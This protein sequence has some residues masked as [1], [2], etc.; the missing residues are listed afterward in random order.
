MAMAIGPASNIFDAA[1]YV[2]VD[3]QLARDR[4]QEYQRVV[5]I[6]VL[7][8]KENERLRKEA[9]DERDARTFME[10]KYNDCVEASIRKRWNWSSFGWGT[11]TGVV[12]ITVLAVAVIP[13]L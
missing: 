8:E 7:C 1:T 6:G 11:V 13:K 3:R 12:S 2:A 9:A 5:K 4:V 10:S